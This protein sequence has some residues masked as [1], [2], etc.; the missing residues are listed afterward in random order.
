MVDS[1]ND[2]TSKHSAPQ[3]EETDYSIHEESGASLSDAV[4]GRRNARE[5]NKLSNYADTGNYRIRKAA[6]GLAMAKAMRP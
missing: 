1:Y 2:D 5:N 3:G 4:S 6:E